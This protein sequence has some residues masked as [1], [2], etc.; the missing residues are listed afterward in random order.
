MFSLRKRLVSKNLYDLPAPA[1]L[2]LAY[3]IGS[4]IG[5]FYGLQVASGLLLSFFYR[6][7]TPFQRIQYLQREV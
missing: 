7:G 2:T 3:G 1:N 6:S 4:I 5:I